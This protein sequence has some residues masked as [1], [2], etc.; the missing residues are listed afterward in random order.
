MESM[1]A[2][3]RNELS[4]AKNA[5]LIRQGVYDVGIVL[6]A[7]LLAGKADMIAETISKF[8]SGGH[9]IEEVATLFALCLWIG[10]F[11]KRYRDWH[12]VDHLEK[13]LDRDELERELGRDLDTDELRNFG[14]D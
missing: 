10:L 6:G 14:L 8:Q 9:S 13:T 11:F 3:Q 4:W 5:K 2:K 1:T 12:S 7:I